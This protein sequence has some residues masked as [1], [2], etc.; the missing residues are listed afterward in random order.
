MP[1]TTEKTTL[2]PTEF[3]GWLKVTQWTDPDGLEPSLS[4]LRIM[5]ECA[6]FKRVLHGCE[7]GDV[8]REHIQA[9]LSV[10]ADELADHICNLNGI[11]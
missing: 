4:R 2:R 7:G 8:D 11:E 3:N 6:G 5:L 10:A 1:T 9:L